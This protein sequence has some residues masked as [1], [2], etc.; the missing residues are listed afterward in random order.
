VSSKKQIKAAEK[1]GGKKAQDILGINKTGG[2]SYFTLEMPLCKGRPD[3]LQKAMDAAN[4]P[5]NI[6][7]T[8][9]KGGANELAKC[10]VTSDNI[11]QVVIL[12]HVPKN[13]ADSKLA[14]NEWYT[15][16][17][18][19]LNGK[20]V[21]KSDEFLMYV[22]KNDPFN[23]YFALKMKDQAICQ[24]VNLLRKHNLIIDDDSDCDMEE[25]YKIAEW[26]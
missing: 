2:M 9:H 13:L 4:V 21:S 3:L 20:I 6:N 16:V 8:E 24:S 14:L 1:E 17:T 18:S 10:L 19:D 7:T 5:V 22:A 11:T 12:F 15:H 26:D 25:I 23:G